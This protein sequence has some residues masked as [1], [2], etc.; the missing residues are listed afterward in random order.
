MEE[1]TN[2]SSTFFISH[3]GLYD[4]VSINHKLHHWIRRLF[5][6]KASFCFQ[7]ANE[8]GLS[9]MHRYEKLINIGKNSSSLHKQT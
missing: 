3:I 8:I 5:A 4:V 1:L 2:N 6:Y 7:F 9:F